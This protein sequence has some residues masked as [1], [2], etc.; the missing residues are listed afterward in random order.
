M[1]IVCLDLEGVLFPEIWINVSLKTKVPELKL[2]TRD[3]S[4]YDELMRHRL[5]IL[6]EK[7][8]K[9]E[10]I[11]NVISTLKPLPGA[12]AFFKKLK[13]R[14][15]AVILSDTYYQ[16]A[17]PLMERLDYPLILCHNLEIG[18]DNFIKDYKI[19]IK[20]SKKQSVIKFKELNFE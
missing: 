15:Q 17:M 9:F 11:K 2:T 8:I 3:I 1:T 12:A 10:E 20:E 4:D 6:K 7:N 18:D 14:F 19:R 5:K 13:E 16:F